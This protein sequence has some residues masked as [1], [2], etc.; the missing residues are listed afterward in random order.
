MA[1]RDLYSSDWFVKAQS[2]VEAQ[3]GSWLILSAKYGLLDPDTVIGP[4]NVTLNSMD[5]SERRAWGQKVVAQLRQ[6]CRAGDQVVVLAGERYR[7]HLVAALK[8]W[9]CRVEIPL[10]GLGIGQQLAWLKRQTVRQ[11]HR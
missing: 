9:G 8:E 6:H 2:F 11:D 10:R 4:Y 7:E 1:A 3:D 5:A